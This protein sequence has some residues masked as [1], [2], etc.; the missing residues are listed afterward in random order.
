M[1]TTSQL[2]EQNSSF[3][4]HHAAADRCRLTGTPEQ[5]LL[6]VAYDLGW[7]TL[8]GQIFNYGAYA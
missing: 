2:V 1:M 6:H 5:P 8:L 4:G 7:R 3:S